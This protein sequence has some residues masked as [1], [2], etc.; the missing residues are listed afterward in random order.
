M[1]IDRLL[2]TAS[3]LGLALGQGLTL[4]ANVSKEEV[5]QPALTMEPAAVVAKSVAKSAWDA[6]DHTR[7]T[8]EGLQE[9]LE[10]LEAATPSEST[11]EGKVIR[12][13]VIQSYVALQVMALPPARRA[14]AMAL[15][16]EL[17]KMILSDTKNPKKSI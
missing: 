3:L 15:A 4:Y 2:L 17:F 13:A 16:Q 8:L 10:S 5:P 9:L 11:D 12:L 6:G 7:D 14:E 1:A